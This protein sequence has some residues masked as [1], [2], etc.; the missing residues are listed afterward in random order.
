[1]SLEGLNSLIQLESIRFDDQELIE[2]MWLLS[3]GGF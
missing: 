1:M 3:Q 2:L